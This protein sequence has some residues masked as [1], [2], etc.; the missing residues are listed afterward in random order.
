MTLEWSRAKR[1]ERGVRREFFVSDAGLL[2]AHTGSSRSRMRA[3]AQR[4]FR[5][6]TDRNDTAGV[7]PVSDIC[8]HFRPL[9]ELE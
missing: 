3:S 2:T 7:E 1:H 8:R 4:R 5:P 9:F 6:F